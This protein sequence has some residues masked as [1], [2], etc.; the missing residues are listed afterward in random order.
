[1]LNAPLVAPLVTLGVLV[2]RDVMQTATPIAIFAVPVTVPK[3]EVVAM[4]VVISAIPRV[5]PRV[6]SA[7]RKWATALC[8]H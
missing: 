3:V 5:I 4:E 8:R 7:I 1:M 2:M 6:T